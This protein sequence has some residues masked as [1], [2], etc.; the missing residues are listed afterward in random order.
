MRFCR[1]RPFASASIVFL[2]CI[3]ALAQTN[4]SSSSSAKR[5]RKAAAAPGSPLDAG[6]VNSGVYRNRQLGFSYTIPAGW[7][8]RTDEM[9]ARDD[10][11][12]EE[13]QADGRRETPASVSQKSGPKPDGSVLLAAFSRPPQAMGEE[14][15][16]SILIAAESVSSYPGLKEAVQYL[17]PLSEVATAQGLTTDG[18]PY[19]IAIG[20]KTLVRQDYHKNV[21]SRIMRQATLAMLMHDYAVSFTFIAGTE[22]EMEDLIDGLTFAAARKPGK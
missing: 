9:N 21:G 15:N 19:E 5:I 6:T 1:V 12:L 20:T 14:V 3:A 16:S 11:N 2:V 4:P 10:D 13:K 18:G 8:L 17:G 7:V 22:Q